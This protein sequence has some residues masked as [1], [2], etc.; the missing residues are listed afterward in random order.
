M[1][2]RPLGNL[3]GRLKARITHIAK[4]LDMRSL[5]AAKYQELVVTRKGIHLKMITASSRVSNEQYSQINSFMT[6]DDLFVN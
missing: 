1:A 5:Y 6:L 4:Y 3:I 2:R